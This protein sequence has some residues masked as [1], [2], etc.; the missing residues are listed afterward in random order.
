MGKLSVY[1]ENSPE[2]LL[3]Y[4][5][6]TDQIATELAKVGV[7]FETWQPKFQLPKDADAQAVMEAYSEDIERLIAS[8]GYQSVDVIRMFPDNEKKVELREK[9]LNE[10]THSEDEVRFFVEG[11]G[12]FYL[13][14]EGKV[15]MAL[16]E[17]GDFISV[18]ANTKHW[19]DMGPS[20]YFT[21]IRLFISPDGWV[22]NFTGQKISEWFPKY[23]S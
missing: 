12:M 11:A 2:N 7:R 1:Q 8:E 4:S 16:C 20:P 6:Q 9:F 22:A 18:P 5:E 21:A 13:H 14:V 23:S 10:H 19:F 17:A 3:F 15:Y